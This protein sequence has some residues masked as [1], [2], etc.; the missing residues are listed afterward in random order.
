LFP[1][2]GFVNDKVADGFGLTVTCVVCVPTHPLAVVP[3]TVYVV[4]TVGFAVTVAP[5]TEDNPVAGD[6]VYVEAPPA[7]KGEDAPLQIVGDVTDNVVVVTTTLTV[8]EAVQPLAAVP[9]SVYIVLVTGQT[10]GESVAPPDETAGDQANELATT[11]LVVVLELLK[12]IDQLL[13]VP[14]SPPAS[15]IT[16]NFQFPFKVHEFNV[17]KEPPS[18]R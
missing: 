2:V 10:V 1:Q 9:V 7:L 15:S 16:I 5:L 4:V 11:V 8:L 13:K 6:Q 17:L 14:P 3:V 12:V 18:G